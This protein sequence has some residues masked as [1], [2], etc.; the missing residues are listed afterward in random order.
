MAAPAFAGC[1]DLAKGNSFSMTRHEPY[2][3]LSNTVSDDATVIEEKETKRNG[4]VQKITTTY[5]N[6]VVAIDRKAESS[7]VQMKVDEDVKS[8]N[9]KKPR[10]A[11]KFPMT[12]LVNGAE[13]D[14]GAI[15]IKTIKKT[16]LQIDGCKY[17]VMIVRTILERT[18]GDPIHEEALLS[19]E[20][21]LLLGNVAMTSKWKA[22]SGV[23]FDEIKAN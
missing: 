11:Y 9:L 8:V 19:L 21:G 15:I 2:I 23:F 22:R 6:G 1:V 5:W 12:L 3:S 14:H 13:V 7:H 10:K 16:N 20:A 18:N 4:S 17:S